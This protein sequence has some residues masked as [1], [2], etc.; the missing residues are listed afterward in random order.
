MNVIILMLP[1]YTMTVMLTNWL[2]TMMHQLITNDFTFVVVYFIKANS[3]Q[4]DHYHKQNTAL[5]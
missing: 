5:L 3:E 4:T 2:C 1:D